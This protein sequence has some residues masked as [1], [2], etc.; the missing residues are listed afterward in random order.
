MAANDSKPAT[1]AD[2][3]VDRLREWGVA[4]IYGYSGDGVNGIVEAIRRTDGAVA[5]VQARHEESAAFMAVGEAKY[6]GGAGVVLSTQGPGAVHLLNGLY[7]AKLDHVPVVAIVGQQHRSVLGSGYLQEIDLPVLFADVAAQ[8]K[9]LVSSPEQVP[10]AIDRAF[11]VALATSSPTVVIVPHDVQSADAP[12]HAHEHGV[13]VTSA[14]LGAGPIVS[15]PT[16]HVRAAADLL[17]SAER[18]AILAGRGAAGTWSELAALAERLG[19]GIVTSLL[20]KPHVDERHPLVAG[21]MGH[22]GTT[23]SAHVLGECDALLIVGSNDPWTEFY[24][25]PGQARAVQIDI[26]TRRI[27]DR[28]PVE[29]GLVGEASVTLRALNGALGATGGTD[30]PGAVGARTAPAGPWADRVRTFIDDWNRIREARANVAAEP[31]N[32]EAAMRALEPHLTADTRIALDVGSVVYWYA[33]QLRLP[34]GVVPHVSSTLASMGGGVPYGLAAKLLA[35]GDPVIVLSGDGGMQMSGL[36][37]LVTV[38]SR[39]QDWTDPRF[40]IAVFDNRDLA[41]VTWEQREIEGAPRFAA[42]QSLPEFPY[43]EYAR[44]LGLDGE[45]VEDSAV[46]D[47]AWG[48]ALAA[49]R[50]YVLALRTDPAMP[51]LPPLAAAGTELLDGLREA[52]RTERD[53]GGPQAERAL[54]LL[55]EYAAIEL[56]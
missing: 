42:S 36:A 34:A 25:A 10:L 16:E 35:P 13:V 43:A 28:Y 21:T 6:G 32:P 12:D 8:Y 5:F 37:E 45:R 53:L 7:D 22:L 41:E 39:W 40:V 26:D 20:G 47:A 2:A 51:M 1:V 29:I 56:G 4:R 17:R 3:I 49:D 50:P 9:V 33:R 11:R 48:R 14:G 30:A 54:R 19:A 46:L 55:E 31:I 27:G 38:A 52:L 23:A 18:P 24:P 15:A 44:A